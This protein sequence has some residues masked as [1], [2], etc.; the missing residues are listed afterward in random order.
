MSP[1]TDALLL[2]TP[3]TSLTCNSLYMCIAITSIIHILIRLQP[4]NEPNSVSALLKAD[5]TIDNRPIFKSPRMTQSNVGPSSVPS[6]TDS[7]LSTLGP[8]VTDADSLEPL[9]CLALQKH[10]YKFILKSIDCSLELGYICKRPVTGWSF[11][12]TLPQKVNSPLVPADV[13]R[14]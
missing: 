9:S 7:L 3:L 8:A 13:M 10:D 6:S 5:P 12:H 14:I 4:Q 11:L 1:C 2:K